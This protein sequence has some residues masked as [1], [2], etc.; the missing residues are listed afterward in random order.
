MTQ[1]I[2]HGLS[3]APS[4]LA[5]IMGAVLAAALAAAPALA[6][7]PPSRPLSR[8]VLA[9]D[10]ARQA[11][12]AQRVYGDPLVR[13]DSERVYDLYCGR[14]S[15]PVGRV[16]LLEG[17]TAASA[18]QASLGPCADGKPFAWSGAGLSQP[19]AI[20]CKGG[21]GDA[22][23]LPAEARLNA[24]R[25]G[26][27]A[28][29]S[30]LPPAAPALEDAIGVL[31][32]TTQPGQGAGGSGSGKALLA[33]LSTVLNG[34]VEGTSPEDY[35]TLVAA[36][37]DSNTLSL[38]SQ[39]EAYFSRA[40]AAHRTFWPDD[41]VGD[42]DL[43]LE[44]ALNL[45]NQRR[46]L[47]A[48][49]LLAEARVEAAA[50]PLELA[51]VDLYAAQ[52]LLNDESNA[53]RARQ[54]QTHLEAARASFAVAERRSDQ[55]LG[56]MQK[57]RTLQV[58]I[59]R[60]SASAAGG[61]YAAASR[62]LQSASDA[63]AVVDEDGDGWLRALVA[64]EQ[65]RLETA[66]RRP[67]N[68]AGILRTAIARLETRAPGSRIDGELYVD[69]GHTLAAAGD[70]GGA[71][72]AYRKAFAI[73]GQQSETAGA[74]PDA[75]VGYIRLLARDSDGRPL[76]GNDPRG[77][78][79]FDAFEAVSGASV[80]QTAAAAA[81]RIESGPDAELIRKLQ[82]AQRDVVRAE[83]DASR[84]D[85]SQDAATARAAAGAEL[86]GAKQAEDQL[87]RDVYARE[88]SYAALA[89]GTMTLAEVQAALEPADMLVRLLVG[90]D[91]GVGLL[92]KKD[93]VT[94]FTFSADASRITGL[95]R[96]IKTSARHE[97][98]S[99]AFDLRA[100]NQ[101][102]DAV[103]GSV[104]GELLSG[105]Q[106]RM[107]LD[108]QGPLASL[109]FEVL[110]L[111]PAADSAAY[112]KAHWLGQRFAVVVSAG[113]R[114]L[115]NRQSGIKTFVGYGAFT[116]LASD[117]SKLQQINRVIAARGLPSSC[118]APLLESLANLPP[119]DGTRAELEAIQANLDG[120]VRLGADFRPEQ[121]ATDAALGQA[122]MVVIATHGV[123]NESNPDEAGSTCLPEAALLASA[124]LADGDIFVDV[125]AV[126]NLRLNARLA[127]LSACD[128]GNPVPVDP[129]QSGLPSGGDALSG[130]ARAFIYAG[131]QTVIVTHW[132]IRDEFG[133]QFMGAFTAA[134]KD[135]LSPEAAL[136]KAQAGAIASSA[137]ADPYFWGAFTPVSM[138]L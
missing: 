105:G 131:A 32:G 122:D 112:G 93:S 5:L 54:A 90:A 16:Y 113:L 65:A 29:G 128:T 125:P 34:D 107:F 85:A 96:T 45:S 36:G 98:D 97:N 123:F 136:Q 94:P 41:R 33:S 1:P 56:S 27:T 2:P 89:G 88:P 55:T 101:L 79:I 58:M 108:V 77:S 47:E 13:R 72:A 80:R 50:D 100:S 4:A 74:T 63:L 8:F 111:D 11:C 110:T 60:V 68:A 10:G 137:Y 121:M 38:F 99:Q 9:P 92:V 39:A 138:G 120:S 53:H 129:G 22:A 62:Y 20:L 102:F 6:A 59:L 64:R 78:D 42:A 124:P 73:L 7:S 66:Q 70:V 115:R 117:A 135:G 12:R 3:R 26:W 134:L 49:R 44:L 95:V 21:A 31:L 14:A 133:P 24:S 132:P 126:L 81:A 127:V 30:A 106:T 87:W 61:D 40:I 84:L 28:A 91:G 37:H 76:A 67:Q 103:F 23:A 51:K 86:K 46:F 69:L 17:P 75:A 52:D 119:L 43:K 35:Q 25:S 118:V 15:D 18:W 71:L 57:L 116:P 104:R 48:R 82:D 130:F 19:A 109:P 114:P 83:V